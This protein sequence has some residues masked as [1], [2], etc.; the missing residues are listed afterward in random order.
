MIKEERLVFG[1]V[2]VWIVVI[3]VHMITCKIMI[4]YRDRAVKIFKY[5]ST[6]NSNKGQT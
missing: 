3:K 1:E 6:V 4:G 5:E 2:T